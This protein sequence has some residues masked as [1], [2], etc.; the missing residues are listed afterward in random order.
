MMVSRVERN[1]RQFMPGD[2]IHRVRLDARDRTRGKVEG[3]VPRSK[4]SAGEEHQGCTKDRFARGIS[5]YPPI[6]HP[7]PR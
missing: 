3:Q 1:E 6:R 2:S 7:M 4:G 5:G